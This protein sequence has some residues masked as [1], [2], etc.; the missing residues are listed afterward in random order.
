[1]TSESWSTIVTQSGQCMRY[2]WRKTEAVR[3]WNC[4]SSLHVWQWYDLFV[5]RFLMRG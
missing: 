4:I 1:M 2:A 3:T 5:T